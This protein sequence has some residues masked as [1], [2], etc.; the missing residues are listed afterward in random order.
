MV[1]VV[2]VGATAAAEVAVAVVAEPTFAAVAVRPCFAELGP[3]AVQS[4]VDAVAAVACFSAEPYLVVAGSYFERSAA[5]V[6]AV[7]AA[8]AP[9]PVVV[10]RQMAD[11]V[12]AAAEAE[13]HLVVEWAMS[14]FAAVAVPHP[15]VRLVVAAVL[16][17]CS[18]LAD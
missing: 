10:L 18:A 7:A 17:Y 3:F 9:Q 4:F 12:L 2:V 6:A 8:V 16:P 15:S 11:L 14:M 13:I 5:L 1:V